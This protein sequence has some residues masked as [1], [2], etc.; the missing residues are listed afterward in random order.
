MKGIKSPSELA[1][2]VET[3][4]KADPA[5]S[6]VL[7]PAR[8]KK[9]GSCATA[10]DYFKGIRL[11]HPSAKLEELTELPRY[12]RSLVKKPAPA[13][14][15]QVSR[16]LV[17]GETHRYDATGWHRAFFKN[18]DVWF[19]VNTGEPVFA[20]DC[21]NVVGKKL[22]Q[23]TPPSKENQCVEF[24]FDVP[25]QAVGGHVH[26]RVGTSTGNPL[27]PE[28]NAQKQGDGSKTAWW[29][30]CDDCLLDVD[31]V[32]SI[33]GSSAGVPHNHLYPITATRQTLYFSTAIWDAVI[34]ICLDD[35]RGLGTCVILHMR[36]IDWNGRYRVEVP[37]SWVWQGDEK[38]PQVKK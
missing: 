36:P 35:A 25:P 37:D 24:V 22:M 23:P 7:D 27:P 8:C 10:Q 9:S 17:K 29:G 34:S 1:T 3:S 16:L 18:E 38:C 11:S 5:G 21:G 15:W 2:L 12:L 33:L 20:G 14:D 19:D 4:L 6:R 26:W 30:K 13:G 32:R 28:C 31:Y